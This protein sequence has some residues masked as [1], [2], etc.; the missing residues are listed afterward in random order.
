ML[1]YESRILFL[2]EFTKELIFN[3]KPA[4]SIPAESI[5]TEDVKEEKI[6][7]SQEIIRPEKY[8]RSVMPLSEKRQTSTLMTQPTTYKEAVT[9]IRILEGIHKPPFQQ[10]KR[11]IL[12][13]N[14]NNQQQ[15]VR[16]SA[17]PITPEIST[18]SGFDLKLPS[19]FD[20][21][22][23]NFLIKDPRVTVIECPGPGKFLIAR[24][25]GRTTLT[26]ISLNQQEIQDII[27]KFSK[28]TRIPIISGLFKAAVGNLILTAVISSLVGDRF[29]LTKITPRFIIEQQQQKK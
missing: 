4:E 6:P 23:L 5:K 21:G 28:E 25:E 1:K 27:E 14:A 12:L 7:T 20:L 19:G 8:I 22:K 2:R 26:K 3:S 17:K 13:E 29:I 10:P 24:T 9:P 15:L 18:I 11:H 16:Q